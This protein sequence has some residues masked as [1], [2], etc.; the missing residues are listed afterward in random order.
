MTPGRQGFMNGYILKEADPVDALG[1]AA[2]GGMALTGE[3]IDKLLPIILAGPPLVG[4]GLGYLHSN[5]TSP[6]EMD[7]A[8]MQQAIELAELQEAE[9]ALRRQNEVAQLTQPRGTSGE[10]SLRI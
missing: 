6:S 9:A 3:A 8:S 1:M 7:A 10:R 4:A 5:A 2:G